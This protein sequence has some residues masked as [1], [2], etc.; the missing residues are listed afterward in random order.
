[1]EEGLPRKVNRQS[2]GTTEI[3]CRRRGARWGR[4]RSSIRRAT[5]E[6]L[7]GGGGGVGE[8]VGKGGGSGIWEVGGVKDGGGVKISRNQL[9]WGLV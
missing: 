9:R 7:N 8:G 4:G 6:S 5:L 3:M 1:M 2:G